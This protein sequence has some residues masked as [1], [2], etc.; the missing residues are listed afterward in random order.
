[1]RKNEVQKKNA[2]FAPENFRG[3]PTSNIIVGCSFD[4]TIDAP[5]VWGMSGH[6]TP[7][8]AGRFFKKCQKIGPGAYFPRQN[9]A[10]YGSNKTNFYRKYILYAWTLFV[11]KGYPP[12]YFP[13]EIMGYSVAMWN[14]VYE[15]KPDFHTVQSRINRRMSKHSVELNYC[16][17]QKIFMQHIRLIHKLF[18]LKI[19]GRFRPIAQI[20]GFFLFFFSRKKST[21][22]F[23]SGKK[24]FGEFFRY[25][26]GVETSRKLFWE[27]T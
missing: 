23:F 8:T 15:Q 26:K 21:I 20:L 19:F 27:T 18:S 3:S 5:R 10:P 11:Y 17:N 2:F 13:A 6:Y 25:P 22:A 12:E 7:A 4:I 1:M 14:F 24:I 9:V 16:S